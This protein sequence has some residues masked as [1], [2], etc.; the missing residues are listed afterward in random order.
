MRHVLGREY[1]LLLKI[2]DRNLT[3]DEFI[4]NFLIYLL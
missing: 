4:F 3:I 2:W 1:F